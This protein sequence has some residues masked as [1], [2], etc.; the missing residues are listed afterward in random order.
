MPA[1]VIFAAACVLAYKLPRVYEASATLLVE[2][3]QIPTDLAS[4]TVTTN[5]SERIQV[6]QQRLMTRD[7]LLQI[8]DKFALYKDE[9]QRLSPT[10]IV[11]RMRKATGINQIDVGS[12]AARRDVGVIGFTVSF[13][14]GD[15]TIA[16]RVANE[17]VSSILSQNI[18][19]RLS[20][21]SETSKF[22]Q[23]QLDKLDQQL[24]AQ[25]KRIADFKRTNESALP[26]SLPYRRTQLLQI[27]SDIA[28]L[29][30]KIQL[31]SQ[32]AAFDSGIGPGDA[33]Q[34]D[35]RLKSKQLQLDH[36]RD[37]RDT[38]A[39]LAE[40]GVVPKNRIKD[41]DTQI[42]TAELDIEATKAQIAAQGGPGGSDQLIDQ[43][44][45]QRDALNQ[46]AA[47]LNDSILK[48]PQVEVELNALTRD[49]QNL[50]T[51]YGQAQAKLAD[52][53]TGERLEEDRQSER[54]EVIEQA[55]APDQ[56]VQPN[57]PRIILAG[58]FGSVAAGAGLVV[59]MELLDKSIRTVADLEKRLQLRPIAIIPYVT[60]FG[61]RRRRG[62]RLVA[63]LLLVVGILAAALLLVHLYYL[64]L[65]VLVERL[66]QKIGL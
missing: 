63:L 18:Q 62:W 56:P 38:L 34:L 31:A 53:A 55:T 4:P 50:Q 28:D 32:P 3:Q 33:Q 27:S 35:Y 64:P 45:A 12:Q 46:K 5:A 9:R 19:S 65:D 29:D 54:F 2:S 30:R 39:P 42:A 20:R 13:Q 66:S 47:A 10:D 58:S 40:K 44:K 1:I 36:Y 59:L 61:E 37:Q 23:D 51:E 14:Y 24:L 48:T 41:L 15:P 21:A 43:L 16:S 22:F 57:R 17:F 26:D 60:T 25:E 11:D 8:A 49:Y 6:I 52:A 7:N